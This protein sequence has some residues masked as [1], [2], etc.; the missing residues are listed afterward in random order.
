M[1]FA[2]SDTTYK[3]I[4]KLGADGRIEARLDEPVTRVAAASTGASTPRS[5]GTT[6][7]QLAPTAPQPTSHSGY[8]DDEHDDRHDESHEHDEREEHDDD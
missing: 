2:S 6:S 4:A 1:T 3:F 7:W 5:G 8:R